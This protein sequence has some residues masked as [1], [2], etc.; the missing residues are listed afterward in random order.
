MIRYFSVPLAL[1]LSVLVGC[2]APG[3]DKNAKT[4]DLSKESVAIISVNMTN[5]YRPNYRVNTMMPHFTQGGSTA[6]PVIGQGTLEDKAEDILVS[7]KLAP[8]KYDLSKLVG[9][10]RGFLINGM[11]DFSVKSEIE[12]APQAVVYLG[13]VKLVNKERI[14]KDDQA[15]GGAL[16]LIDQAVSGFSG[17]TMS[18]S[19]FDRYEQDVSLFKDSFPVLKGVDIVRSP[20]KQMVIRRAYNSNASPITIAMESDKK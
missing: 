4:L 20:I 1:C 16:P 17:G 11:L 12:I 19:L 18:V 9:V 2:A 13:H 3:L 6:Q 5:E 14:S 7:V 15:S 8:G 10:A